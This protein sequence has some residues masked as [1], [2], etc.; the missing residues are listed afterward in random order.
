MFASLRRQLTVLLEQ[1]SRYDFV[2]Y[3]IIKYRLMHV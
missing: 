3:I 2:V 1:K